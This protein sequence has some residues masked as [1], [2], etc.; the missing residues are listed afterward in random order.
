MYEDPYL[1]TDEK[2]WD[3]GLF[4]FRVDLPAADAARR[5]LTPLAG[6]AGGVTTST[7]SATEGSSRATPTICPTNRSG[8]RKI[9]SNRVGGPGFTSSLAQ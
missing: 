4:G 1:T 3:N 2:T 9:D 5:R 6:Q 7:R 8:T